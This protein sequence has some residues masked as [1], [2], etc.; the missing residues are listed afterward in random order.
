MQTF[1]PYKDFDKSAQVLDRQRLG[2]QR[3]EA[4]QILETLLNEPI[5]SANPRTGWKNH[6]A[7]LMWTG[8]EHHLCLYGM[9]IC[10]EWI[11][12]GYK[13]SQFQIFFEYLKRFS[14]TP[15]PFWLGDERLH[16][17]HQSNL[18]R[19]MPEY[20]SSKFPGVTNDIPYFWPVQI[21]KTDHE[22]FK[23]L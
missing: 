1:L 5:K 23:E 18:I 9:A 17:S 3:V 6:P 7:V 16:L 2:K 12:R 4:R 15:E 20:Y 22:P 13:D 21:K 19:K 10:R 11:S 14:I 8:C